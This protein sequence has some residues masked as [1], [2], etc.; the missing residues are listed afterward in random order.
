M[1]V[2]CLYLYTASMQVLVETYIDSQEV[3]TAKPDD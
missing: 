2:L 3:H 1:H